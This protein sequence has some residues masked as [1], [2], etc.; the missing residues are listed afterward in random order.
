[1]SEQEYVD[2]AEAFRLR[3]EFSHVED[4]DDLQPSREQVL[5]SKVNSPSALVG[6]GFRFGV[7]E[8]VGH[9]PATNGRCG[10]FSKF[11]AC[12]KVHLHN[13]TTFDVKTGSLVN[14]AGKADIHPVFYSCDK[15]SC[16]RCYE[17]GWGVRFADNINFRFKECNK[18]LD[19]VAF[20]DPEHV[21]LSFPSELWGLDEVRLREIC[22]KALKERG[23]V[24]GAIIFHPARF[25]DEH[26]WHLGIH[27]HV[28]GYIR[29]GFRKCRGCSHVDNRG[30]RFHCNGCDGFYGVS[31]KCYKSDRIICEVKEKRKSIFSTAWYQGHHMGIR[32]DQKRTNTVTWFG[33]CSYR[34]MKIPKEALKEYEKE[35]KAK[36]RICGSELVQH[37][38]CG[39]DANVLAFLRKVRGA[40]EKVENFYGLA[41][42]FVE[43]PEVRKWGSGSY[44]E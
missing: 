28:I 39:C 21:I 16:M 14:F 19:H 33:V 8:L 25:G 5:H 36:C 23:V 12:T 34:R 9:R 43:C 24:G 18:Q 40:R 1:M 37:E 22:L 2:A 4:F 29:G 10:T 11:L 6:G 26:R 17:R 3:Q 32:T 41:S 27:F 44:D 31:K 15:P 38:Y 20:G 7:W 13:K 35:R 42:D 30:S